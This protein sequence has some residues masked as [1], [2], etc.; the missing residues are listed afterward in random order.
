[1]IGT[2]GDGTSYWSEESRLI[3]TNTTFHVESV[4][5][6]SPYSTITI[7][8]LGGTVGEVMQMTEHHPVFTK[9]ERSRLFLEPIADNTYEVVGL[10]QG[11]QDARSAGHAHAVSSCESGTAGEGYCVGGYRWRWDYKPVSF[12]VNP[13]TADVSGEES[14]VAAAFDS[15]ENDPNSNIDFRY[16]GTTTAACSAADGTPAA[17]WS[18]ADCSLCSGNYLACASAG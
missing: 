8:A 5:R 16:D 10:D 13:N 2:A 7:R 6:G 18:H 11:K 17:Y 4:E 9:G 1:M 12:R 3:F 14:A 15:W